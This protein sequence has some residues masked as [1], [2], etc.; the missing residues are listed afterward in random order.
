MNAFFEAIQVGDI[1]SVI[2]M[3]SQESSLVDLVEGDMTGLMWACQLRNAELVKNLLEYG[4]DPNLGSEEMETPLHV[5]AFEGD[6]KIVQALL[7]YGANFAAP[8][9]DGK[10]PLMNAAQ[11]GSTDLIK[12]L[13]DAGANPTT[14]DTSGRTCLHWAAIG[15]HDDASLVRLVVTA[16][17]DVGVAN[18]NGDTALDYARAMSKMRI[19][20]ELEK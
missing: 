6:V 19:Q 20:S 2:Q 11:S 4:A 3:L 7:S 14:R 9:V 13:L 15:D 18:A 12:L 8:T 17:V 16:G 1:A 10:T 5:A